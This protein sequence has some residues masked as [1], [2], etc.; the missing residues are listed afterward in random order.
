MAGSSFVRCSGE[1]TYVFYSFSNKVNLRESLF[2]ISTYE[3]NSYGEAVCASEN[4]KKT[5]RITYGNV[6]DFTTLCQDQ[7]GTVHTASIGFGCKFESS[8][9]G[10]HKGTQFFVD[11]MPAC[12]PKSCESDEDKNEQFDYLVDLIYSDFYAN[13]CQRAYSSAS[14]FDL[15]VA[16]FIAILSFVG[17]MVL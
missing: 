3:Q 4:W 6:S 11:D 5:C 12:I 7:N 16:S 8:F 10:F 9:A 15:R 1:E 14:I 2:N 17:I 13:L